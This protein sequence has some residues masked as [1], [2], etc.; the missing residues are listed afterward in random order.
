MNLM[1]SNIKNDEK[2]PDNKIIKNDGKNPDNKKIKNDEKIKNDGKTPLRRSA[3]TPVP[4]RKKLETFQYIN[5][6]NIVIK[7]N[8]S[9]F[10][11]NPSKDGDCSHH[12][13]PINLSKANHSKGEAPVPGN[14]KKCLRKLSN[15]NVKLEKFY[16]QKVFIVKILLKIFM[17]LF[18]CKAKFC[19]KIVPYTNNLGQCYWSPKKLFG[20]FGQS[21]SLTSE[22]NFELQRKGINLY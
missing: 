20:L 12:I 15:H 8:M 13:N 1:Y 22:A 9:K 7:I 16:F 10:K 4:S 2:N 21:R 11:I 17:L 14:S 6:S 18:F 19:T 5:T 3:R